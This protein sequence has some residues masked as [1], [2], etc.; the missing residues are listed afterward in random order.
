MTD[1]CA[2]TGKWFRLCHPRGRISPPDDLST[3]QLI[4]QIHEKPDIMK[5]WE[6][7]PFPSPLHSNLDYVYTIDQ[8][9]GAFIISLW[10]EENDGYLANHEVFIFV[11]DALL[12]FIVMMIMHFAHQSQVNCRIGKG[13]SYFEKVVVLR[14]LFGVSMTEMA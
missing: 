13:H 11:F 6:M 12:I 9:A 7:I 8:D 10:K 2:S 4:K 3:F 1:L 5:Q 14:E